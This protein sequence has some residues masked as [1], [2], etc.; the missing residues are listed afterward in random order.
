MSRPKY[1]K[2]EVRHRA[3]AEALRAES[4]RT[5]YAALEPCAYCQQHHEPGH[6][7]VADDTMED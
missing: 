5:D 1:V 3:E 2:A 7:Q 4:S 6:C